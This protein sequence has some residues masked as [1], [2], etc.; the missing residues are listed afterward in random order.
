MPRY[1]NSLILQRERERASSSFP[2]PSFPSPFTAFTSYRSAPYPYSVPLYLLPPQSTSSTSSRLSIVFSSSLF[3]HPV[4]SFLFF[5]FHLPAYECAGVICLFVWFLLLCVIIIIFL[6]VLGWHQGRGAR[7]GPRA[8][9]AEEEDGARIRPPVMR[10]CSRMRGLMS[11]M[12]RWVMVAGLSSIVMWSVLC[13]FLLF[14]FTN[15]ISF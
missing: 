9:V 11:K 10:I 7:P 1:T 6:C 8:A 12:T 3:L 15:K 13:L 2:H 14:F 4:G 5:F